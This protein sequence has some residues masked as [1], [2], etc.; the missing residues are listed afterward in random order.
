[1]EKSMSLNDFSDTEKYFIKLAAEDWNDPDDT[2]FSLTYTCEDIGET[3]LIWHG[4]D[5]DGFPFITVQGKGSNRLIMNTYHRNMNGTDESFKMQKN[6]IT[7]L[8]KMDKVKKGWLIS[9]GFITEN[10]YIR[11]VY[12][13]PPRGIGELDW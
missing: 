10:A 4:Q 11:S 8:L 1:M 3:V 7:E 9:M 12:P 2:N 5:M 13:D 6:F